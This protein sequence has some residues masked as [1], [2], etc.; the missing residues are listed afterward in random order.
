MANLNFKNKKVI[1]NEIAFSKYDVSSIHSPAETFKK[2]VKDDDF[3]NLNNLCKTIQNFAKETLGKNL[4]EKEAYRLLQESDFYDQTFLNLAYQCI[5]KYHTLG[6]KTINEG[7]INTSSWYSHVLYAGKAC[8]K[9]AQMQGLNENAAWTLGLIHDYGRK[10]DHSFNHVVLGADALIDMGW[11]EEAKAA[12]THSF[13]KGGRCA[14]NEQALKGFHV[15]KNGNES[16]DETAEFDDVSLF[17][18]NYKYTGYDLILNIADLM[19]T[20]KGIVSPYE[21]I[22]DIATR[23]KIDPTNRGYFLAEFNNLLVEFLQYSVIEADIS[24][25]KTIKATPDVSLEEIEN[26]FK[27]TSQIFYEIYRNSNPERGQKEDLSLTRKK[28]E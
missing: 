17:L 18:Q 5:E 1:L 28:A 6:T 9:M 10:F 11:N 21:R 24:Q 27:N 20:D 16:W 25:L 3:E 2:L 23:R 22:K 15:D 8:Q 26:N 19:A 14:S 13:V 12:I 7:K 4:T